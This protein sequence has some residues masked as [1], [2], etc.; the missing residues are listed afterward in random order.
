MRGQ[1][2]VQ[3]LHHRFAQAPALPRGQHRDIHHLQETAAVADQA[4]HR[5]QRFALADAYR[6]HRIGQAK[7]GGLFRFRAQPGRHA[8]GAILLHRRGHM[9]TLQAVRQGHGG[10]RTGE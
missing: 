3:R 9:E 5:Q 1:P 10:T 7:R 6:E 2:L 8:Q 4:A